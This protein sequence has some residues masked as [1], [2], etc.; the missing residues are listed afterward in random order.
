MTEHKSPEERSEEIILAAM[1]LIDEHGLDGLTME[2]VVA[3]TSLSKGGVYRFF[4]NRQELIR[5]VFEH[6]VAAFHPV[7]PK[8][9]LAWN[10]PLKETLL[11]LLFTT[12]RRDDGWRY[13]RV[14][15]R[16][17]PHLPANDPA[18]LAFR[19]RLDRILVVYAE[20]ILAVVERDELTPRAEFGETM[21]DSVAVGQ[22]LFDGLMMNSLAGVEL[23]ELEHRMST[24][25][26]LVLGACFEQRPDPTA[27]TQQEK[28]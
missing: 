12:F 27:R 3:R 23:A 8:E 26:D 10:L 25:I 14:H 1:D 21:R 15:L 13:R 24:F 16:L 5:K 11:K 17:M 6:I 28:R 9:A 7:D 20:I 22:S 4:G 19:E 2:A 18:T